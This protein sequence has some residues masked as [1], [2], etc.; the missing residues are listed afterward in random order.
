MQEAHSPTRTGVK[1]AWSDNTRSQGPFNLVASSLAGPKIRNAS[2]RKLSVSL[3]SV[4]ARG[5]PVEFPGSFP[6]TPHDPPHSARDASV[7]AQPETS[8]SDRHRY[9]SLLAEMFTAGSDTL[10]SSAAPASHAL[11]SSHEDFLNGSLGSRRMTSRHGASQDQQ[12]NTL[13]IGQASDPRLITPT[14]VAKSPS[15][16][17]GRQAQLMPKDEIMPTS[18]HLLAETDAPS[19]GTSE[20][21]RFLMSTGPQDHGRLARHGAGADDGLPP[22]A[23]PAGHWKSGRLMSKLSSRLNVEG[24][25]KSNKALASSAGG[26]PID[27]ASNSSAASTEAQNAISREFDAQ[28]NSANLIKKVLPN[29]TSFFTTEGH[30]APAS[31]AN[32]DSRASGRSILRSDPPTPSVRTGS[33][34]DSYLQRKPPPS[35]IPRVTVQHEEGSSASLQSLH[36]RISKGQSPTEGRSAPLERLRSIHSVTKRSLS[37]AGAS[38]RAS[39]L[40][41]LHVDESAEGGEDAIEQLTE[42]VTT[43]RHAMLSSLS[44]SRS[45]DVNIIRQS[46]RNPPKQLRNQA[47]HSTSILADSSTSDSNIATSSTR[48][49]LQKHVPRRRMSLPKRLSGPESA[50]PY[51]PKYFSASGQGFFERRK[52][53]SDRQRYDSHEDVG[54]LLSQD[55][56][57]LARHRVSNDTALKPG[58]RDSSTGSLPTGSLGIVQDAR[59]RTGSLPPSS[60]SFRSLQVGRSSTGAPIIADAKHGAGTSNQRSRYRRSIISL[61]TRDRAQSFAEE[62]TLPY[63]DPL[64]SQDSIREDSRVRIAKD[65]TAAV[66]EFSRL[67]S[68]QPLRQPLTQSHA[69]LSGASRKLQ[70]GAAAATAPHSD[71]ALHISNSTQILTPQNQ[72]SAETLSESLATS[73]P[74]AAVS[75]PATSNVTGN[76][77]TRADPA[78]RSEADGGSQTIVGDLQTSKVSNLQKHHSES[79]L[80]PRSGPPSPPSDSVADTLRQLEG[81]EEEMQPLQPSASGPSG[82][83]G[84]AALRGDGAK[85]QSATAD[86]AFKSRTSMIVD[87]LPLLNVDDMATS[88]FS[89]TSSEDAVSLHEEMDSSDPAAVEYTTG[90]KMSLY[91]ESVKNSDSRKCAEILEQ[92]VPASPDSWVIEN[93]IPSRPVVDSTGRAPSAPQD[94]QGSH[95]HPDPVEVLNDGRQSKSRPTSPADT[96]MSCTVRPDRNDTSRDFSRVLGSCVGAASRA[97]DS[98][99]L[100]M[101]DGVDGSPTGQARDHIAGSRLSYSGLSSRSNASS[102]YTALQQARNDA[103]LAESTARASSVRSRQLAKRCVTVLERVAEVCALSSDVKHAADP[104]RTRA[105]WGVETYDQAQRLVKDL[106]SFIEEIPTNHREVAARRGVDG[107]A[108]VMHAQRVSTSQATLIRSKGPMRDTGDSAQ[109]RQRSTSAS[110]SGLSIKTANEVLPPCPTLPHSSP[111]SP[112]TPFKSSVSA[113]SSPMS[114]TFAMRPLSLS[115]TSRS[116]LFSPTRKAKESSGS[117]STRSTSSTTSRAGQIPSGLPGTLNASRYVMAPEEAASWLHNLSPMPSPD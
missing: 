98:G 92:P 109:Q 29:G 38:A 89:C 10:E 79:R 56:A 24:K 85:K 64:R 42:K 111:E 72:L 3:D 33:K 117:A 37:L 55:V 50:L 52:G 65:A 102:L 114:S 6:P 97:S 75:E 113:T 71:P 57:P 26:S 35:M 53:R 51:L 104:N 13:S 21:A 28:L 2:H 93:E 94:S 82:P 99:S 78:H 66:Q 45:D 54:P 95:A 58:A 74:M 11:E 88:R 67:K 108:L 12:G 91:R 27:D 39:G 77:S 30:R 112:S 69:V 34:R 90:K 59:W 4:R 31:K 5:A 46:A 107:T 36:G 87:G 47:S 84:S 70:L 86:L 22:L 60:A 25:F 14:K 80:R 110:S 115:R 116:D 1:V 49:T 101:S 8:W 43:P 23:S 20:L 15:V 81:C 73:T 61:P 83:Y 9:P 76:L 63:M 7:A 19:T 18:R 40:L 16:P 68:V 17:R 106:L 103:L 48:D 105:A 62:S 96:D 32:L 100:E 44:P 41:G